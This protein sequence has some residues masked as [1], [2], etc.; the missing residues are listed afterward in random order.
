M[1][2][3]LFIWLMFVV[4]PA[5]SFAS[6]TA[7]CPASIE[8]KQQAPK[9]PAGWRAYEQLLVCRNVGYQLLDKNTTMV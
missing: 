4:T 7:Q 2:K 1:D 8:V 5:A 9:V 3:R 6:E